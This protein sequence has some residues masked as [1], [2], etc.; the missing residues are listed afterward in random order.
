[1]KLNVSLMFQNML[2]LYPPNI[3]INI[4]HTIH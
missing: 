1:M 4:L 3:S 2:T